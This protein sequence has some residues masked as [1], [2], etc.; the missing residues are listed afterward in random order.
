VATGALSALATP[1]D[2]SAEQKVANYLQ[3]STSELQMFARAM[4]R[5]TRGVAGMKLSD[6][7]ELAG[8][9]RVVSGENM[10]LLSEYGYGKRVAFDEFTIHGRATGGQRIY[11]VSE[12]TGEIVGCVTVKDGEEIMCITSQGKSIKIDADSIR[13]MG[14]SASG[15]RIVNIDK[16]DFV[17][18][19]DR[20]V[21]EEDAQ[22]SAEAIE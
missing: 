22:V 14:R 15:V 8:V 21:Q 17:V 18:G 6:D 1:G 11:T 2:L 20:I 12:K 7:D 19:V 16:P 5:N 9:L 13:V 4:G 3:A 10:M